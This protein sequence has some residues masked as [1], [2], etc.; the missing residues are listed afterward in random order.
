[1]TL[2]KCD[3]L[4]IGYSSNKVLNKVNLE[5]N[6]GEFICIVGNNGTGKTTL[7]KTLL[8]LT[9]AI[10]GRIVYDHTVKNTMGYLQQN[11]QVNEDF[12]ATV[13]EIVL[14]GCL[15]KMGYR[16]F[17]GKK[18]KELALG[19]MKELGILELKNMPF[20]RLSGGQ[21]QRVLIARA[22]CSTEKILFLD[23]PL[24]GL[25]FNA[26]NQLFEIISHINKEYGVTIVMITH[27]IEIALKY[28]SKI[29]YLDLGKSFVG[30]P[31]E[32]LESEYAKS[33]VGGDDHDDPSQH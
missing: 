1:M 3:N 20:K 29:V 23:E 21:Q 10:S 5:I 28:I 31:K 9:P 30:T 19:Y 25:D 11:L 2:I 32:F 14:S 12:P 18:E 17:Y 22:L 15:S 7:V 26:S 33:L 16:M 4:K 13:Y 6:N 8:R 27:N 24:K